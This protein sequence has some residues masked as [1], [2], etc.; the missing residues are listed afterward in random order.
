LL[1]TVEADCAWL[2]N[3]TYFD[4]LELY[5]PYLLERDSCALD[6]MAGGY[7]FLEEP[8]ELEMLA[9]RTNEDLQSAIENRHKRGEMLQQGVEDY[10]L[11]VRRL[12]ENENVISL[13]AMNAVPSWLSFD[14]THEIEITS[15]APYRG[16]A[17]SLAQAILNWQEKGIHIVIGTDQPT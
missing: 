5:L 14:K 11:P 15:L 1:D 12:G 8:L 10:Q 7:V 2:S 13:S 17:E 3:E 4:R 9:G 6:Y 16:R